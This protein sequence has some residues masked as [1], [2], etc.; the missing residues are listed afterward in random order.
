MDWAD[1]PRVRGL[2]CYLVGGAVR[3]RLLGLAAPDR[4]FVVVGA[5]VEAML[6]RGFR[7]VGRDFP[8]F[9]HPDTGEEYALARTE[10]KTAPGYHG[11]SFHAGPEV[12]LEDDLLR[13]DLTVNAIAMAADGRLID[14]HGGQ[15]DLAQRCLRHVS[16]AFR[17]DPV[18]ILRLARFAARFE[19]FAVADETLGLCRDMVAAGEVAH[20]VPERVWQEMAR[21][22]MLPRPSRFFE[23]LRDVGALA[24]IL[25]E[26]EA[27]FG[28]P[29]PPRYHPEI[30]TGLHT[31]LVLDQ[32]ARLDAP[33]A[34]RFSALVHDLGKALTPTSEWPAHR[35]HER[36]GLAPIRAV[37]DRFGV[38]T[39]CRELAL[40]VGEFHLHAHRA[41]ELRPDTV[42]GLLDR[43]D[44]WRR[45]ERLDLFL[46]AC[47]AD[48]RG[49][50]G[51]E[52]DPYPQADYLRRAQREAATVDIGALLARG[53][54]GAELG[55]ALRGERL[56]RIAELK[57]AI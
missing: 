36:R 57:Q 10:R 7:A 22:L 4:D 56:A 3:D 50:H 5:T 12:S 43:L 54:A 40:L 1:D 48:V 8:V 24:V 13:R 33:L 9:I 26:V 47:Q 32:A 53:L 38:P 30:D 51:R 18:R 31:L 17:E 29:Q 6:E 20:L 41:F 34:V 39:A 16:A 11:F 42:L 25:P 49:R 21:A 35:G 45:P 14:P 55:R 44:V 37:C 15:A 27:L 28:V 2:D 46:L 19:S 52:D 23:L